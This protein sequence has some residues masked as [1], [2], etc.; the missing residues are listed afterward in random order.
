MQADPRRRRIGL[1]V[2]RGFVPCRRLAESLA[3]PEAKADREHRVGSAGERLLPRTADGEGMILR[4]GALA[5]PPG[6]DRYARLFG[7]GSELRPGRGPEDAVAGNDQRALRRGQD[8]DRA[9]DAARDRLPSGGRR[10]RRPW[11]RGVEPSPSRAGRG[12]SSGSRPASRLAAPPSPRGKPGGDRPRSPTSRAP[13]S[14]IWKR[15]GR[16]RCHRPPGT[17]RDRP[18]W[19]GAGRR[20]R[21]PRS[22]QVPPCTDR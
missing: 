22:R 18:R 12:C 8:F 9:C 14:P 19:S 17:S 7:E 6:I 5:A 2:A 4:E 11:R 13:A 10:P 21:R 16:P 15:S 20:C 3:T 1:D